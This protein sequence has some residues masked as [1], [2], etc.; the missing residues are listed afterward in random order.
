MRV[1]GLVMGVLLVLHGGAV[2][3][4][5]SLQQELAQVKAGVKSILLGLEA[6]DLEQMSVGGEFGGGFEVE[7]A[8][9]IELALRARGERLFTES[10]YNLSLYM[11]ARAQG[12]QTTAVR[13]LETELAQQAHAPL[14]KW[15]KVKKADLLRLIKAKQQDSF[16]VDNEF[17][18]L[19]RLLSN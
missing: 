2:L 8:P 14:I 17:A 3:G 10:Y 12:H 1:L 6:F 5:Q 16:N 19:E 18:E 11:L 9:K 7:V 13:A 15:L 4:A